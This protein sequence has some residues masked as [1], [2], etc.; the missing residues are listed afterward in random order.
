MGIEQK[1][2]AVCYLWLDCNNDQNPSSGYDDLNLLLMHCGA[3]SQELWEKSENWEW[4]MEQSN[5]ITNTENMKTHMF[6]PTCFDFCKEMMSR[7]LSV[8][9]KNE[10]HLEI[11]NPVSQKFLLHK[12]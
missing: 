9:I 8:D 4:W 1:E 2:Q 3:H 12:K 6:R 5:T 11:T 7:G 10:I